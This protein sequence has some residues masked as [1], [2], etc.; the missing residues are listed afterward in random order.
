VASRSNLDVNRP[1]P[2]FPRPSM[3]PHGG[4][5][6]PVAVAVAAAVLLPH[7]DVGGTVPTPAPVPAALAIP[8]AASQAALA[9]AVELSTRFSLTGTAGAP[10][11]ATDQVT[12]EL[13]DTVEFRTGDGRLAAVVSR[14][15]DGHLMRVIDVTDPPRGDAPA[16]DPAEVPVMARRLLGIAQVAAPPTVPGTTW[17]AGMDAWCVRWE[18]TIGGVPAPTDGLVTWVRPDGRLKALS[19]LASP[20]ATAPA[21]P[22]PAAAA[23]AAVRAY[24]AQQRL[25]R[26]PSLS[27][28]APRLE[29]ILPDG[30]VDPAGAQTGAILRLAWAVRFSY[31]P[32]G[33]QE[34]HIVELDVDAASG[35]LIGGTE[36]A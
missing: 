33:W 1:A 26:L 2:Y 11:R 23:S 12:G 8:A 9:A 14:G 27:Y 15:A 18:R 31:V 20:L 36:S 24:A 7:A 10:V 13:T 19:D 25:D 16:L 17:D 6:L 4:V 22:I 3:R 30:F 29:W 32:P 21:D 34:R 35:A 28:E 5:T